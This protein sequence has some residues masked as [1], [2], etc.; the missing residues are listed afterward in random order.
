[1]QKDNFVLVMIAL[2]FVM[3]LLALV[4]LGLYQNLLELRESYK[5]TTKNLQYHQDWLFNQ[6]YSMSPG[7]VL[8][9]DE[10]EE[11]VESMPAT[12]YN[13]NKDPMSEFTGKKNDWF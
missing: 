6:L 8:K 1:M 9:P 11:K 2:V 10:I 4:L 3:F 7:K 5:L 13:P 12:V